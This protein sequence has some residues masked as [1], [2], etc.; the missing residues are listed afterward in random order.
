[1]N[2]E[3]TNK[4]IIDQINK[5]KNNIIKQQKEKEIEDQ[6]YL[7]NDNLILNN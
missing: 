1:M 4:F 3:L 7:Q 5:R 6:N 2:T